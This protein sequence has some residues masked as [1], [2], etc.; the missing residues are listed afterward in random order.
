MVNR[1]PQQDLGARCECITPRS[2]SVAKRHR[3]LLLI[4]VAI[5]GLSPWFPS[6]VARA[7]QTVY[8]KVL[9]DEDEP[10]RREIW[11]DRLRSRL[12]AASEV[13]EEYTGMRFAIQEFDTWE[14][15]DRITDFARSFAEFEREVDPAPAQLAIGF[16]SQYV[17]PE[18]QVR[19]GGTRGPLYSYI[20]LREAAPQTRETERVALLVHELG[21]FFGAAHSGDRESIMQPTL[22]RFR[23]RVRGAPILFDD[24]NAAVMRLVAGEVDSLRVRRFADLS[25]TTRSRLLDYYERLV[26]ELPDDG[27]AARYRDY[28]QRLE[29]AD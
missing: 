18:R 1:L 5:L 29:E 11:E 2:T 14:S 12:A 20:L 3:W 4:V 21:H 26:D 13:M 23:T 15:D 7:D 10:A 22:D 24:D 6:R 8:V 25:P 17:V 27:S 28:L 9:V 19:G 16:S